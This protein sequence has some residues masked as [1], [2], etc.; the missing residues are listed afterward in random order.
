MRPELII[1]HGQSLS[2]IVKSAPRLD[3]LLGQNDRGAYWLL[4][5][6]VFQLC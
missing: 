3:H 4:L 2:V 5:P 6:H 1:V